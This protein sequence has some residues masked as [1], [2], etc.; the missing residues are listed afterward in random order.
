MKCLKIID[1][2]KKY[3]EVMENWNHHKD[4]CTKVMWPLTT[5]SK[6]FYVS[7]QNDEDKFEK[8]KMVT[9]G[10]ARKMKKMFQTKS[11]WKA[12]FKPL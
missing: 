12:C 8:A 2:E 1:M 3:Y 5:N 11:T 4:Q 6:T 10:F 9:F 7:N